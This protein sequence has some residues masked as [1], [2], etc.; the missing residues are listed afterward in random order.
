[1][2][3]VHSVHSSGSQLAQ[4]AQQQRE[5]RPVRPTAEQTGTDH[6]FS[7]YDRAL[8]YLFIEIYRPKGPSSGRETI[9]RASRAACST[10]VAGCVLPTRSTMA[11]LVFRN[12]TVVDGNVRPPLDSAFPFSASPSLLAFLGGTCTGCSAASFFV[13]CADVPVRSAI[14]F[15]RFSALCRHVRRCVAVGGAGHVCPLADRV[16]RS[17][18][19]LACFGLN[20]ACACAQGG[21]PFVGDVAIKG[22]KILA[23]GPNLKVTGTEEIDATGKHLMPGWTD[24][25]SHMDAQ[26]MWDPL[27]QPSAAG[28][29]TTV[30]MG[31]C[32]VSAAPCRKE[33]RDFMLHLLEGVEVP[34][35]SLEQSSR[36]TRRTG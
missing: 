35:L 36:P 17:V 28:G 27:L 10:T 4:Q 21:L 30:V 16:G 19:V 24:V 11:D 18:R 20:L 32:G 31:N 23:V 13:F 1:M 25:H 12:G 26:C 7:F 34:C 14:A 5:Q 3:R 8:V 33:H 15:P 6:S 9:A 22:D 29:V 2:H